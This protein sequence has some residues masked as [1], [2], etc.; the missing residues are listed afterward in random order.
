MIKQYIK[1]AEKLGRKLAKYIN[2]SPVKSEQYSFFQIRPFKYSEHKI[3][4][5]IGF[6]TNFS[7][8][9]KNISFFV[10]GNSA[11]IK[12]FAKVPK[13]IEKYFENAFYASFPTSELLKIDPT[14][15]ENHYKYSGYINFSPPTKEKLQFLSV[16][17]FSSQ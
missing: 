2:F 11:N 5:W 9:K 1:T 10:K 12:L 14:T 15:W 8:I 13:N 16:D 17:D 6:L 7:N 4:E 3:G